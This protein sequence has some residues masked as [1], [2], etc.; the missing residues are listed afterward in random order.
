[1]KFI[2]LKILALLFLFM[3]S[4]VY[5]LVDYSETVPVSQSETQL[6]KPNKVE[7]RAAMNASNS[8]NNGLSLGLSS[9]FHHQSFSDQAKFNKTIVSV[10]IETPI[11]VWFKGSYW[12]GGASGFVD[13]SL[14]TT[15]KGNPELILGFNFLKVGS[16]QDLSAMDIYA[17][18]ELSSSSSLASS[19]TDQI[20][21][22]ELSKRFFDMALGLGYELRTTGK[23]KN[24][25]DYD[26]GNIQ[27]IK[28]T[29]GWMVSND[30]QF[31]TDFVT[32]NIGK[33]SGDLGLGSKVQYSTLAPRLILK[34]AQF[35][36]FTM[37]ADFLVQ[38]PA[39][40]IDTSRLKINSFAPTGT[41]L[42]A[43]LGLS[44]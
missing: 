33:G 12:Q 21:G 40:D 2:S 30:I 27:R 3:P 24:N 18:S 37:G 14:N 13:S 10:E 7:K 39:R 29:F 23:S 36:N 11:D 41:S 15:H 8:L 28:A 20:Y 35:V 9:E 44:F 43:G 22:V 34:L 5:G 6:K 32:T 31:S 26:L 38:R 16:S 17:G 4:L 19:R 42:I 25:D 1:M